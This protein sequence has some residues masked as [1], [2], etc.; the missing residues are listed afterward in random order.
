MV[1]SACNYYILETCIPI[2]THLKGGRRNKQEEGRR[3]TQEDRRRNPQEEGRRN[4]REDRRKNPQ[5]KG[6]RKTMGDIRRNSQEK[7]RRNI[8]RMA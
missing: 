7:G 2:G 4:T 5:G 1:T 8:R 6:R 3:K